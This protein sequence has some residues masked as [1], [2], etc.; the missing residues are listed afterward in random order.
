M[1]PVSTDTLGRRRRISTAT[2]TSQLFKLGFRNTYL[3]GGKSLASSLRIAGEAVRA[4][5]E[6]WKKK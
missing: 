1:I 5:Y 6:A 3:T 2:L 4:E